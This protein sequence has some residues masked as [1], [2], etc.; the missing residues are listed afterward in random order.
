MKQHH[1]DQE[2]EDPSEDTDMPDYKVGYK[3]PPKSSQFHKGQSGNPNGRPKGT[4]NLKTDLQ[5]ELS[6]SIRV[7][8]GGRTVVISKQRAI[9]KRTIELALKGKVQA[10]QLV[11]KLMGTHLDINET[12]DQEA[13]VSQD[14]Q[15]LLDQFF[16]GRLQA[17]EVQQTKNRGV[18]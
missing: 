15:A 10:T 11:T 12:E 3:N 8:E 14:D 13:P 7:T 17:L 9:V 16:E 1:E 4:K 2:K 18:T 6:E 5:E